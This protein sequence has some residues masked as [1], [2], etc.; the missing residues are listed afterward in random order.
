MRHYSRI[1][2]G[3]A[4]LGLI[5]SCSEPFTNPEAKP[6]SGISVE[7]SVVGPLAARAIARAMAEPEIRKQ[8]LGDMRDSPVSEHKLVLQNYLATPAGDRV[9]VAIQHAGFD[10][11]RLRNDVQELGPIQFYVPSTSQ[12][13][14]W[15]G[16]AD[17]V[18]ASSLSAIPNVGFSPSGGTV[19][20]AL[21][22]GTLPNGTL[23]ILQWAEPMFKRW[24][25]PT[26]ATE[27]IQLPGESQMGSGQVLRD[28]TG[29]IVSTTDD[30]PPGSWRITR[31]AM[32]GEPAGTYLTTLVNHGVCD[33]EC[34][35]GEDL[36]F[37]FRSTASDDPNEFISE[38]LTGIEPG[39]DQNPSIWTGLWKVHTS[40]VINGVTIIVQVWETDA[41]PDPDD[42]FY[43]QSGHPSCAPNIT[44]WPYLNGSVWSF[45]LCEDQPV[46]CNHLPSDLEVSFT[47]RSDPVVSQ[48]TVAPTPA[49]I[50]KGATQS[51]SA[52]VKDQYGDV[53]PNKIVAWS[54]TNTAVATVAS[55]G[56]LTGLATGQAGGTASIR[57][58]A[59]GITGSG[60]LTVLAPATLTVSPSSATICP[61]G[62][63]GK[64]LTATVLD[65]NG[66]VWSSGTV[67]WSSSNTSIATVSST[68]TRTSHVSGVSSGQDT[69]TGTLDGATGQSSITVGSCPQV[70]ITGPSRVQP[71]ATC[72]W[73]ANPS[74]GTPPYGYA[75]WPL[76]DSPPGELTYTN[77]GQNFNMQV[78]VTDA[79][80]LKA[81]ATRSI[82]VSSTAPAC[83][84]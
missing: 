62:I 43:C 32:A 10:A 8:I 55:T 19:P 6:A 46:G 21:N 68:D 64:D 59:D 3:V 49:T 29:R 74:G 1:L 53:M 22:N 84:M 65:Q 71:H 63:N 24:A 81:L 39:S 37:E 34:I 36:E 77:D 41:A 70:T 20:L 15:K 79:N 47:D 17:I 54:S 28:A 58:T 31:S 56:D 12:R 23:F 75:W 82:T 76:A 2:A 80:G 73:F 11:T 18:V 45:P 27:T 69:V 67:A 16:T 44:N 5:S 14:T 9:L 51:Y 26:A 83:T 57:A 48:V 60:N 40:R 7:A 42:P 50:N 38:S 25:G 13:S 78:W 52:T 4:T 66:G 35:L 72:S 30:T 61:S 33:H